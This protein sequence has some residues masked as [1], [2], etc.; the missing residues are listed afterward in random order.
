MCENALNEKTDMIKAEIRPETPLQ[1]QSASASCLG[2]PTSRR[3][4]AIAQGGP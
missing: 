1:L 4:E 2:E 3:H